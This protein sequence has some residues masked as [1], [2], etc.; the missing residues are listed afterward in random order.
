MSAQMPNEES[1]IKLMFD[2][3]DRLRQFGWREAMYAPKDGTHFQIIENG[4]TGIFD[5]AY[6]GE[7]PNGQ[8]MLYDQ[9]DCYPSSISPALFRLYPKDEKERKRRMSSASAK[10]RMIDLLDA[11]QKEQAT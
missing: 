11:W 10:F 1:A 5:C 4:S 8:W 9:Y 2:A 6:S 7:W 3:Y